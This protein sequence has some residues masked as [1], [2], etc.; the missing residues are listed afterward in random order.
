MSPNFCIAP[1]PRLD[2][3]DQVCRAPK[4]ISPASEAQAPAFV[5]ATPP[6]ESAEPLPPPWIRDSAEFR[7]ALLRN[8]FGNP[9]PPSSNSGPDFGNPLAYSLWA[10]LPA[11]C[12]EHPPLGSEAGNGGGDGG[13]DA[14]GP[15][16]LR[17][18]GFEVHDT[19]PCGAQGMVTD[20]DEGLGVCANYVSNHHHLFSWDAARSG[21]ATSIVPLSYAPDQLLHGSGGEIYITTHQSPGLAVVNPAESSESHHAFPASIPTSG[22]SSRGRSLSAIQPAFPKG[23]VELGDQ[24][25]VATSNYDVVHDDYQPG[26]VLA[27]QIGTGNFGVLST[28]GYNPTS[29]GSSAGR[30][31]V[32]SSGA[33]DRYGAASTDGFL[34]VFDPLSHER[35]RSIPLGRRGA[36]VSGELAIS[37]DGRFALLPTADNSGGLLVVDLVSSGLREISL[38]GA[39]VSGS[40]IFFP[41]LSFSGDGS[42]ALVANFNDGRVY[43]VALSDGLSGPALTLDPNT[44]DGIGLSDGLR[45]GGDYFFGLGPQLLK[46]RSRP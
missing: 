4:D 1:R 3:S 9:P 8:A 35:L 20:L 6:L 27:Y 38:A 12:S 45:I 16:P 23:L 30:L 13:T 39:G 7:R 28:S 31:L 33:I 11:G 41:N 19:T 29:V 25:F 15:R 18:A 2:L 24:I 44:A 14:T 40:R 36:G 10:L 34:D 46:V 26:T 21:V 32:V 37:P 43:P 17:L 42:S 5:R 22:H